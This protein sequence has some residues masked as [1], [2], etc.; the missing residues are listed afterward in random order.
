MDYVNEIIKNYQFLEKKLKLHFI[1][2]ESTEDEG[3]FNKLNVSENV[4]GIWI[5]KECNA[6]KYSDKNRWWASNGS[7][8]VFELGCALGKSEHIF[9]SH[10]DMMGCYSNFIS[11]LKDR[12]SS[13]VLFASF[14]QRHLYPF[15]GGM[16]FSRNTWLD[17][18]TDALAQ[19][20]NSYPFHSDFLKCPKFSE[21]SKMLDVGENYAN[22]ALEKGKRIYIAPSFG[23]TGKSFA[24]PL[25]D[26][27][28]IHPSLVNREFTQIE[29]DV[30]QVDW[31]EFEKNYPDLSSV[32]YSM[33]RKSFSD[34]GELLFIHA[35]R[36]VITKG[37]TK[38]VDFLSYLKEFNQKLESQP[39]HANESFTA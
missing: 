32:E 15:P 30:A 7:S 18:K 16:I 33:W 31:G 27:Y 2:I 11:W 23:M 9:F 21:R 13:E 10:S 26:D 22:E 36:G 14:S 3:H 8:L 25:Y 28:D 29:Y 12:L 37:S 5:P 1:V 34:K 35:G 39:F 20:E 38:R 24:H 19:N 4:T 17:S 6:V